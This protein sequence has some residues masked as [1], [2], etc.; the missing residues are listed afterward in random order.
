MTDLEDRGGPVTALRDLGIAAVTA[1]RF[2][3]AL[4]FFRRALECGPAPD[5]ALLIA[6]CLAH[7]QGL[8]AALGS[9]AEA[10]LVPPGLTPAS[11]DDWE[12]L[13]RIRPA[14]AVSVFF[15]FDA[16]RR[17]ADA[18]RIGLQ[19][20]NAGTEHE[21]RRLYVRLPVLLL[22][23]GQ[24]IAAGQIFLQSAALGFPAVD[25]RPRIPA[26]AVSHYAPA[27]AAEM[28]AADLARYDQALRAAEAGGAT[29]AVDVRAPLYSPPRAAVSLGDA[30]GATGAV[31]CG[32]VAAT[33]AGARYR[34]EY[35]TQADA[36]TLSTPWK[37]VPPPRSARVRDLLY[38]QI[39]HWQPTCA[40]FSLKPVQAG[41]GIPD[42]DGRLCLR[43]GAPFARDRNQL[44]GIG[45]HEMPLGFSWV[46]GLS[47][48]GLSVSAGQMDLRDAEIAFTVRGA[49]L[50]QRGAALHFWIGRNATDDTGAFASQWALTGTPFPDQALEDGAWHTVAFTLPDNP[51]AWTYTGNNPGEQGARATRY[52]RLPLHETLSANN[53]PFVLIFAFGPDPTPPL[54]Y[55][56][57]Y[58]VS[59][60]YRDHSLLSAAAGAQL[61][62]S[63]R[64]GVCDP[65]H[66]TGGV[67]G[68]DAA[69]W[70]SGPAPRFPLVFSWRLPRPVQVTHF[71]INQHPYWPAKQT[72]VWATDDTGGETLLWSGALPDGRADSGA[73]PYFRADVPE[74][75][76][77]RC[78]GIALRILSGYHEARC[79]LDG[80]EV[81]GEG[82]VFMGDGAPCTVSEEVAGL[83][84][85]T[86][87]F[88]RLVVEEGGNRTESNVAA[89]TLPADR[90]PILE[91]AVPLTRGAGRE[92]VMVRGNAMGLETELWGEWISAGGAVVAGE[93]LSFGCQPTGR[94]ILYPAPV[95]RGLPGRLVIR[96]RNAEGAALCEVLGWGA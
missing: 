9:A 46:H 48:A 64:T 72:E 78:T 70:T 18:A 81:Y 30:V 3:E 69:L 51:R 73:A 95:P 34:I 4:V 44:N 23:C 10:G 85:G 16:L 74:Q 45:S 87:V 1:K 14:Q 83:P 84:A 58:E 91:S 41:Q 57:L 96:A 65:L 59:A 17:N 33:A 77:R 55:L 61:I 94:H 40:S 92:C 32:T 25:F 22:K 50:E 20:W 56:D 76:A 15:L 19:A 52:R 27:A 28:L 31:L 93:R 35:G 43:F 12:F 24:S 75:G 11:L 47:Q 21:R 88:Y 80:V 13:G 54:G 53:A 29:W 71:Q 82:A 42:G 79:G 5:I 49:S 60:R 90:A 2:D 68:E 63:P 66:V 6:V 7:T 38:R 62:D 37:P 36:L 39:G 26:H 8:A 86:Q 89:L 67:R